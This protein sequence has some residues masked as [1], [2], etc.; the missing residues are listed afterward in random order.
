MEKYFY[1]S[2]ALLISGKLRFLLYSGTSVISDKLPFLQQIFLSFLDFPFLLQTF[3]ISSVDL[4]FLQQTFLS[5]FQ[6]FPSF[7]RPSF[8]FLDLPFL[9]RT[10]FPLVDIPFLQQTFLSF[11]RPSFLLVGL[12]FLHQTFLSFSRPSFILNRPSFSFLNLSLVDLSFP[13]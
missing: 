6:T 3:F 13:F 1:L 7:S 5:F 11:S 10:F 9:S 4:L 12:Q 8:L 2:L